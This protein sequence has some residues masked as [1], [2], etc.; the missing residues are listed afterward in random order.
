MYIIKNI[1]R[2]RR[3][4]GFCRHHFNSSELH[5]KWYQQKV[6]YDYSNI[7]NN[8]ININNDGN[9]N[10]NK[11]PPIS[12]EDAH[13]QKHFNSTSNKII[14]PKNFHNKQQPHTQF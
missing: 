4:N 10:G 11:S 9:G 3:W 8:N 7:G 6:Y 5:Q 12:I 1:H 2:Y 14:L 13:T